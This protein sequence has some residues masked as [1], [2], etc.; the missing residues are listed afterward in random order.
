MTK[1]YTPQI[2]VIYHVNKLKNKNFML[3]SINSGKT[4][5]KIQYSFMITLNKVDIERTYLNITKPT[6]NKPIANIILNSKKL[7]TFFSKIRS[8]I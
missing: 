5:D 7:K 1:C 2:N 8:K 3:I 4:S 6:Y